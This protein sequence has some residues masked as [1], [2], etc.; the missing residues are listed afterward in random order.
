ML[1][2]GQ[3]LRLETVHVRCRW[4]GAGR[5]DHAVEGLTPT[6]PTDAGHGQRAGE[7]EREVGGRRAGDG[8]DGASEPATA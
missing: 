7:R 2:H 8:H 3:P 5:S 1:D 6:P 4:S